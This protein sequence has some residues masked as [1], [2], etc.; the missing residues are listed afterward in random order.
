MAILQQGGFVFSRFLC[1]SSG[2]R[3]TMPLRRRDSE[4]DMSA[5]GGG[6]AGGSWSVLVAI[7]SRL[8]TD[9]LEVGNNSSALITRCQIIDNQWIVVVFREAFKFKLHTTSRETHH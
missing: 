3:L 4:S 7:L 8:D 1:H 5:R 6:D 2:S 9:H